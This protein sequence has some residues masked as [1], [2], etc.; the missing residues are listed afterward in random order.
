MCKTEKTF[1]LKMA[2]MLPIFC[3]A[4]AFFITGCGQDRNEEMKVHQEAETAAKDLMSQQIQKKPFCTAITNYTPETF[5]FCR[6]VK[7]QDDT[8][9]EVTGTYRCTFGCDTNKNF[10]EVKMKQNFMM[11]K[12]ENDTWE[13]VSDQEI[14]I[15]KSSAEEN[16]DAVKQLEESKYTAFL[17]RHDAS[18]KTLQQIAQTL[19]YDFMLQL[20]DQT[21]EKKTF[22]PAAIHDQ[23]DELYRVND[24]S[25]LNG[26]YGDAKNIWESVGGIYGNY[27]GYIEGLGYEGPLFSE[28]WDKI[29]EHRLNQANVL[30]VEKE[31]G[32]YLEWK[33]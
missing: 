13:N 18:G 1:K 26:D 22:I 8:R 17:S 14:T 12:S 6:E 16:S 11:R 24:F 10:L 3:L 28:D 15:L 27:I 19:L 33:L 20:S 32:Y 7:D 9:Y 2:V 30:I 21:E 23:V 31:D 25:K 29:K 5:T 4:L